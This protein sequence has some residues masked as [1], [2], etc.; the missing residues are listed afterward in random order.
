PLARADLGRQGEAVTELVVGHA[1]LARLQPALDEAR[2]R[3]QPL[4][5]GRVVADQTLGQGQFVHPQEGRRTRAKVSY[6]RPGVLTSAARLRGF[7]RRML[8]VKP[9]IGAALAVLAVAAL[10]ATAHAQ[11]ADTTPPVIAITPP[12]DS[13]PSYKVGDPVQASYSC[14]DNESQVTACTGP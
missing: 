9:R 4:D 2:A 11:T 1:D 3:A 12:A 7:E 10:P 6:S 13:T 8:R 5:T 14:T